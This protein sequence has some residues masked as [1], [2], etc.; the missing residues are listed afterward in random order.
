MS[1]TANTSTT[2]NLR[3]NLSQLLQDSNAILKKV[4]QS[5]SELLENCEEE[6]SGFAF[7]HLALYLLFLILGFALGYVYVSY[8]REPSNEAY[9]N[10]Y[11]SAFHGDSDV[12]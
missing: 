3:N 4:H 5:S 10:K 1:S 9:Y 11:P 2:E 6:N 8:R 7:V 12:F